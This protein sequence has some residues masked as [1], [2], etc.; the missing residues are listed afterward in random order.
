[1][2]ELAMFEK[3]LGQK[4][5]LGYTEVI[6]EINDSLNRIAS[7]E[8]GN[9][10]LDEDIKGEIILMF[11]NISMSVIKQCLSHNGKANTK[12]NTSTAELVETREHL[13]HQDD[14]EYITDMVDKDYNWDFIDNNDEDYS[15]P[16][17]D[18][19]PT[20]NGRK[21]LYKV[22]GKY[23]YAKRTKDFQCDQ[24]EYRANSTHTINNH[25]N[26]V[27][28]KLKPY[29]CTECETKFSHE[30]TLKLHIKSVHDQVKDQRCYY[31]GC[32]YTTSNRGYLP[33]HIKSVHMKVKDFACTMCNYKASLKTT[34][35]THFKAVHTNIK[36]AACDMC[37]YK[38]TTNSRLKRHKKTQHDI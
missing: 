37:E 29:S 4:W 6:H 8:G 20:A 38:T 31:E 22:D 36:D 16:T 23:K 34:L 21:Y 7:P 15:I 30:S 26:A 32:D 33:L 28:L 17:G 13:K 3:R 12:Q 25:V 2:G 27:H 24:C 5:G 9:E 11:L 35:D 18:I 1:M 14:K 10:D 19:S